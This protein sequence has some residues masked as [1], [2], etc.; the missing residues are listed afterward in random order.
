MK[1]QKIEGKYVFFENFSKDE[2][3]I[4]KI[5]IEKCF[6]ENGIKGLKDN[7]ILG[8]YLEILEFKVN[9]SDISIRKSDSTYFIYLKGVQ[10]LILVEKY[11]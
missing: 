1:L 10:I 6:D 2:I 11:K 3:D 5:I 9:F 7:N 8:K 4:I